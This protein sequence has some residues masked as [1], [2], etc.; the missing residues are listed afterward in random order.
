GTVSSMVAGTSGMASAIIRIVTAGILAGALIES[1]AAERIAEAI[2]NK[3]GENRCLIA[4]MLATWV[5]TAVGVFG[6]VAVITV[7]PVAML[8][9][10]RAGYHK[11]GVLMAMIGGVKA[12]NVMSPNPNAIAA[13]EAFGVPLTSVIAVG[14]LPAITALVVTTF[15]ARSLAQKG[16]AVT[17]D[18]LVLVEKKDL[19]SLAA[20]LSGPAVTIV[21][22]LLRPLAGIT[23]DP[24]IALPAGGIVGTIVMGK[25]KDLLRYFQEGLAKMSGV[26]MLL[27]GTGALSGIISNSELNNAITGLIE[28]MGL[29]TVLLAP[30][31]GILMGAA[32]ASATAGTTLASQIFGSTVVASGVAPLS[33][34]AMSHAGSF[35]FDGLPH[36]SFFHVSAG[37]VNMEISERLKLIAY[38]SINGLAMVAVSTLV[39]GVLR[40]LG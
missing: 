2:L 14:V 28:S 40:V 3:L 35:A 10:Q 26:A 37:A 36:G 23:V 19:P 31:A 30:I 39:F 11:L 12:G 34:A 13:S 32:T 17:A 27:I 24:L 20:A 6:D 16:T 21:L 1:G 22:L 38:E 9:A 15:L 25:A 7:A 18:D 8:M 5:L 4:M 29:P 33:A